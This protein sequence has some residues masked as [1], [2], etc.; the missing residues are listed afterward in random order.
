MAVPEELLR[1]LVTQ[2]ELAWA[3]LLGEVQAAFDKTLAK[4]AEECPD[5]M[6]IQGGTFCSDVRTRVLLMNGINAKSGC[7]DP[8]R[9][10]P[11]GASCGP[12]S[13]LKMT[14][15]PSSSV[16]LGDTKRVA[17]ARL[18]H[19][20]PEEAEEAGALGPQPM[21]VPRSGTQMAFDATEM[22]SGPQVMGPPG[23][24]DQYEFIAY[25]WESPGRLSVAG[26]I[27]AMVA[28][29]DTKDERIVAFVKLPAAIRPKTAAEMVLHDQGEDEDVRDFEDLLPPESPSGTGDFEA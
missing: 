29:L 23:I 20:S 12:G 14:S 24:G 11:E 28:D 13:T 4:W 15:G 17:W 18:R 27:L 8:P 5:P 10:P 26:A 19:L 1:D 22:E 7:E 2:H 21:P 9:P 16:R 25:W 3:K 6:Q